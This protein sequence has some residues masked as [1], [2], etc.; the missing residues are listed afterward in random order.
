VG[1]LP[2]Q[3]FAESFTDWGYG[4]I[5]THAAWRGFSSC[6]REIKDKQRNWQKE[7]DGN[8]TIDRVGKKGKREEGKKTNQQLGWEY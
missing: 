5:E 3:K 1:F 6:Y 8:K 4:K 7:K 2:L